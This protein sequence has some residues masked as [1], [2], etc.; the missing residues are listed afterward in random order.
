MWND[1]SPCKGSQN[2]KPT[3]AMNASI[4]PVLSESAKGCSFVFTLFR[5][6]LRGR[7]YRD[8]SAP[9]Y[10]PGLQGG[11]CTRSS[12]EVEFTPLL[13]TLQ[14]FYGLMFSCM[15]ELVRS[16]L[17]DAVE[18]RRGHRSGREE[19]YAVYKEGVVGITSTG[20]WNGTSFEMRQQSHEG[21]RVVLADDHP[22]LRD[23]LK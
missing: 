12:S 9:S 8:C 3:A 14:P 21:L 19:R 7:F 13:Q 16:S 15:L 2:A 6:S 23:G 5:P 11:P 22:V 1:S 4:S 18:V 17:F 20:S 10:L